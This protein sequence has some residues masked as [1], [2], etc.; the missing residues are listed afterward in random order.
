MSNVTYYFIDIEGV[1]PFNVEEIALV[2]KSLSLNN[3]KFRKWVIKPNFTSHQNAPFCSCISRN[4]QCRKYCITEAQ[5]EMIEFINE[6]PG[7][8]IICGHG[9]DVERKCLEMT[10][11]LIQWSNYRFMSFQLPPWIERDAEEYHKNAKYLKDSK[12]FCQAHTLVYRPS[13]NKSGVLTFSSQIKYKYGYHCALIDAF[14][15]AMFSGMVT[16][17]MIFLLLEKE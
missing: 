11:P 2:R 5:H 6:I 10:F 4:V 9:T 7:N 13:Y 15:L 8:R 17:Q 14:E 16:F 3:L 1:A 12:L